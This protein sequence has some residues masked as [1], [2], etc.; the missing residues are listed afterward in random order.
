MR[1]SYKSGCDYFVLKR[2][3]GFIQTS[4]LT[5]KSFICYSSLRLL[6]ELF[7]IFKN[8]MLKKGPTTAMARHVKQEDYSSRTSGP[9]E[10]GLEV[11]DP[12]TRKKYIR[13][14]FLGKVSIEVLKSRCFTNGFGHS[15]TIRHSSTVTSVKIQPNFWLRFR[16]F[17]LTILGRFCQVL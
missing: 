9:K 14:K 2:S 6:E 11:V 15:K 1:E 8:I 3:C 17:H 12:K 16:T 5:F 10:I 13:G 7:Q 4:L